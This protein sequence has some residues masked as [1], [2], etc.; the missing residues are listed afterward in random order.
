MGTSLLWLGV[1]IATWLPVG[2]LHARLWQA[3][4]GDGVIQ[5]DWRRRLET[6]EARLGAEILICT[7]YA[8]VT[9]IAVILAGVLLLAALLYLGTGLAW[10]YM[11][12]FVSPEPLASETR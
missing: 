6:T 4:L 8:G 2:W 11:R 7:G 10:L 5:I 3:A 1:A 12:Y 9:V